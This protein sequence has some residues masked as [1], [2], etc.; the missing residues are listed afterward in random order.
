MPLGQ[1][2]HPHSQ[3]TGG[4]HSFQAGI[5]NFF[6]HVKIPKLKGGW[7]DVLLNRHQKC[8]FFPGGNWGVKPSHSVSHAGEGSIGSGQ[9]PCCLKD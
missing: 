5:L 3:L 9:S 6:F 7:G 8:Q 4:W 1:A 2:W